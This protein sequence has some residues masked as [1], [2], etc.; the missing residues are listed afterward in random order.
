[1]AISGFRLFSS[2][3]SVVSGTEEIERHWRIWNNVLRDEETVFGK[4]DLFDKPLRLTEKAVADDLTSVAV[5][6][7]E[8]SGEISPLP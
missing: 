8:E 5:L 7:M 1:M 3:N 2:E 6:V 4:P